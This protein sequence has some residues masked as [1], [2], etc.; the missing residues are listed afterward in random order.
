MNEI[1]TP[2]RKKTVIINAYYPERCYRLLL[3]QEQIDFYYW[4]KNEGLINHEEWIITVFDEGD[5]KVI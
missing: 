4:L 2:E 1:Q 5:W 3:T